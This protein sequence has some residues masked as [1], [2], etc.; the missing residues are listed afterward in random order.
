MPDKPGFEIATRQK[1]DVL[2]SSSVPLGAGS[3]LTLAIKRVIG[4]DAVAV[5][6]L[7]DAAFVVRVREANAKDGDFVVTQLLSSTLVGSDQTVCQRVLPCGTFMTLEITTPAGAMS[8]FSLA[9]LGV[10]EP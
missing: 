8:F 3:S 9:G 2:F 1:T 6:A 10:P 5:L 7:S 4:Y